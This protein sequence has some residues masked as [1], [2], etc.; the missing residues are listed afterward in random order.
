MRRKKKQ[1]EK[2]GNILESI[3]QERGYATI[4][5]EYEVVSRWSGVV[6]ERIAKETEC[7]RVED[8]RLYVKVFSASWRQEL[9]YLKEQLLDT[10]RRETGCDSI[11]EIIFY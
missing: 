10:I 4:C 8:G 6:G 7:N 1:P 9:V 3:L 5:R 2:L 11:K